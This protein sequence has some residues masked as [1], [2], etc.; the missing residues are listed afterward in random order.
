MPKFRIDA[1]HEVLK[2]PGGHARHWTVLEGVLEE[3]TLRLGAVLAIP[4]VGGGSWVSTVLGFA[5]FRAEL[6]DSIDATSEAGRSV[7]VAVWGVAPPRGTVATG[8]A[9][10]IGLAEARDLVAQL[11]LLEPD[12]FRHCPDCQRI[13]RFEAPVGG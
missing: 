6:G 12:V 7:G 4:R 5:R 8:E 9:H 2:D 13:E 10:A 1:A 3:G 11:R